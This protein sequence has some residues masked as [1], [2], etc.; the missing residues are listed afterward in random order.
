MLRPDR[1]KLMGPVVFN[2]RYMNSD[3]ED[4]GE[5]GGGGG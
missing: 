5:E 4:P 2:F 1:R 3:V